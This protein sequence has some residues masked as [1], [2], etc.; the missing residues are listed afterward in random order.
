VA[1]LVARAYGAQCHLG[2]DFEFGFCPISLTEAGKGDPVVGHMLPDQGLFEWHTDHYGLPE[3]AINLATGTEYP[4]QCF[5]IGRATY[6]MQFHFEITQDIVEGWIR[7]TGDFC[8]RNVPGYQDWLPGQ[9]ETHMD[10]SMDFCRTA[11]RNWL[12]L[13]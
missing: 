7:M 1:Q 6:A 10:A 3:G 12:A 13:R 4:N 8:E 5:C 9:F 2:R 11:T